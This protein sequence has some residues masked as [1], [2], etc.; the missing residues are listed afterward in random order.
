MRKQLETVPESEVLPLITETGHM[1]LSRL[2]NLTMPHNLTPQT[3][4]PTMMSHMAHSQPTTP[5][6]DGDFWSM[7]MDASLESR[8]NYLS[9]YTN[10]TSS[11]YLSL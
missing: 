7:E 1:K 11:T 10:A 6:D 8:G 9:C 4:P 2:S 3:P 5:G